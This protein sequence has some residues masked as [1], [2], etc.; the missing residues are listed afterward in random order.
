M[1]RSASARISALTFT[2]CLTCL[3]AAAQQEP[4]VFAGALF[5]MSILSADG[6]SVTTGSEAALSLYKPE[7]G[8]ALNLLAGVHLAPYFSVQANWVWNRN[9]L[10]LVSSFTTPQGGGF[11]EQRRHS[12][13][14]AIV[15]DGLVYFRRPDSAVRPYLG[16]GLSVV[17]FSS[18]DVVGS[19]NH[20]LVPHR[21]AFS[22][23]YRPEI[24]APRQLP[25][26][27]Q[28]NHH[29]EPDQPRVDTAGA[30]PAGKFSKPLRIRAPLL[31]IMEI[32]VRAA[33]PEDGRMLQSLAERPGMAHATRVHRAD[34]PSNRQDGQ[35]ALEHAQAAAG[36]LR[37]RQIEQRSR[38]G[39]APHD[40]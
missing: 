35:R 30:A 8:P 31:T 21:R 13:Q 32:R 25:V 38:L 16:T 6:R 7:N 17:Q 27:L 26:Q 4:R 36:L 24:V 33:R 3:P 1:P 5:G 14:H 11:Y 22:R 29:R 18:A 39:H 34:I 12:R 15:V 20:G 9:D 40:C 19:S 10:T 23:W 2:L 28:R 37:S